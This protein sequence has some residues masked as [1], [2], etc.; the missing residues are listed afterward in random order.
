MAAMQCTHRLPIEHDMQA[1]RPRAPRGGPP[2]EDATDRG[3]VIVAHLASL[4]SVG[5]LVIGLALGSIAMARCFTGT[6]AS[7]GL[8]ATAPDDGGGSRTG[9]TET[10]AGSSR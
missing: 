9:T 6:A 5:A 7:P 8:A 4:L 1:I 2:G 3:L 10:V